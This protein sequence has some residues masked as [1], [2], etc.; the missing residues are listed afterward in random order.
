MAGVPQQVPEGLPD[1]VPEELPEGRTEPDGSAVVRVLG[2]NIRSLKDDPAETA[3]V[4][5]ACRPDVLCVQEAPRFWRWARKSADFASACEMLWVGGGRPAS[6]PM[7]LTS[8]RM[9]VEWTEDVLLP[10]TPGLHQRGFAVAGLRVGEGA[11]APRLTA[12]SCHLSLSPGERAEQARAAL[13]RV[14]GR[15]PCVVAGDINEGPGGAAWSLLAGELDDAWGTAAW[16][17][18]WTSE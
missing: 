12:L 5:R 2:Y 4:V 1:G 3:R 8:P 6:G 13:E 18:E 17:G 11:A 14:A 15:G 16:G 7:L 9:R 10:R